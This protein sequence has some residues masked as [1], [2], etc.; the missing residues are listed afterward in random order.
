MQH[1]NIIDRL[2]PPTEA[3]FRYHA[4]SDRQLAVLLDR[5]CE[6]LP[7]DSMLAPILVQAA[8]RLKRSGAGRLPMCE[9]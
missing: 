7:C 2:R 3:W 9:E 4:M 8:Q 5:E 1:T 6:Q